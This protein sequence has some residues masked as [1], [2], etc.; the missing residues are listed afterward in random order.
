[1][2]SMKRK[3][4]KNA[5]PTAK[6]KGEKAVRITGY[7]CGAII[8]LLFFSY[9]LRQ[10]VFPEGATTRI[11]AAAVSACALLPLLIYPLLK[12]RL[13]RFAYGLLCI[14]TALALF[15]C[16]TFVI[17]LWDTLFFPAE[18]AEASE[19][20]DGAV[21]LVF[22][23]KIQGTQPAPPL[24]KRLDMAVA[25]LNARPDLIC[26]VAGGQGDDEIMPEGEA[27]KN[28]LVAKG[29]S[30]ERV[31]AE[32]KSR[33]TIA[34]IANSKAIMTDMGLEGRQV[35]CISSSFH[36]PR[37]GL[38]MERAGFENVCYFPAP[39]PT[40]ASLFFSLIREYCSRAKIIF[41]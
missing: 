37:I 33:N 7:I 23:S 35:A 14:Y 8:F 28:Y 5:A 31:I 6:I 36:I 39:S 40:P 27:M 25:V 30:E 16:V 19:L 13:P 20:E 34:N 17:H 32:T 9:F 24:K 38:L 1:M 3:K 18:S 4:L 15:F 10:F 12:R 41:G 11:F 21:V 26:I 2:A 29:I 22:G